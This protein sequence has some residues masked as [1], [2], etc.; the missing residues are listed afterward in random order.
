MI[1]IPSNSI[2][3]LLEK[4]KSE[5]PQTIVSEEEYSQAEKRINNEM[6]AFSIEQRI[7]FN[8]SAQSA[9]KAYLTF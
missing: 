7:Y 2:V 1:E 8:E 9:R 6:E 3:L 5:H 4:L